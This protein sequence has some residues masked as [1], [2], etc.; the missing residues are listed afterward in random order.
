MNDDDRLRR[1]NILLIMTDQQRWDALGCTGGWVKT[2]HIDRIAREGIRF[3]NCVANSPQCVPTRVSLA[4]GLYPHNTGV[5]RHC[6]YQLPCSTPTWMQA[7]RSAGYQTSVFGKTHLHPHEGDLRDREFLL[8]AYGLEDIDEATGPA[9]STR[10]LSHMTA[11]WASNRVLESYKRDFQDRRRTKRH[12]VRPSPLPLEDYYD[13]YVGRQAARYLQRYRRSDPW[14]CWVSF[15]GPHEPWDAPQPYASMYD[16]ADMPP[17]LEL[18]ADS[19]RRPRGRLDDLLTS[20]RV[21]FQPGEIGRL[22]ANYAGNVSLIDD[23]VGEILGLIERRGELDRTVI[24]FTSDHGEMNGDYQLLY[25]GNFLASAVHVP[26]LVV[27]PELRRSE[28]AG[29]VCDSPVEWFDIGPTLVELADGTLRHKQFGRSFA[30]VLADPACTHRPSALSEYHGE[31]MLATADWKIALNRNGQ[32]YLLFDARENP[33][34]VRNL[35]GLPEVRDV[36]RDLHLRVLD[37]LAHSQTG[38]ASE[39][40]PSGC[41]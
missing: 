38:E 16:P 4:T 20:N 34:E 11:Q 19:A 28:R 37:R 33:Q 17:P 31:V 40:G 21:A 36:E 3:A 6:R 30:P 24:L 32:P 27:T 15:P 39:A 26:L 9:A 23:Q 35:A 41:R 18:A 1:P 25:K 13:V 22:R 8:R 2:P 5:W 10:S 14:F 7:I 12:V 29:S